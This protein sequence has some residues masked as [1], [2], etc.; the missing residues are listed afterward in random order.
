VVVIHQDE[1]TLRYF[2]SKALALRVMNYLVPRS[3]NEQ[4]GRLG[5]VRPLPEGPQLEQECEVN[6][7]YA[8]KLL[9]VKRE[10]PVPLP[11]G[12][13]R[14]RDEITFFLPWVDGGSEQD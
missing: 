7:Y 4:C 1:S 5:S 11:Y 13:N 10:K 6:R 8:L 9:K 14:R 3:M 2:C 12:F